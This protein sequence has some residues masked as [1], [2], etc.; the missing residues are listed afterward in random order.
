[1]TENP[2]IYSLVVTTKYLDL[3]SENLIPRTHFHNLVSHYDNLPAGGNDISSS[4]NDLLT[5]GNES[6]KNYR[7]TV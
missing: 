5:C 4:G 2:S 3:T 6:K 7:K 1:M